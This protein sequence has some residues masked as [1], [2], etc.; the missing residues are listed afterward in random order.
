MMNG[1]K[2]NRLNILFALFFCF[3]GASLHAQKG[4]ISGTVSGESGKYLDLVN[5]VLDD[6]KTGT[7]TNS[8][9]Y[10]E[11]AVPANDSTIIYAKYVGYLVAS[12]KIF[13]KEGEH[14]TVNF[15]LKA[16]ATDIDGVTIEDREIR[17]STFSSIDPKTVLVI[18][19][20]SGDIGSLIKTLPGVSASNELSSQYSVR[21]GSYDENIIYVNGIEIFRPFLTRTG[22]QEGLSFVNSDLISSIYF[23]AGGFE[24]RYGDKMSSVLDIKYRKPTEFHVSATLSLLSSSLHI[25]DKIGKFTYLV[26]VRQKTSSY[27][28]GSLDTKGEYKPSFTD[29]QGL[30]TYSFNK[31]WELSFLGN[32]SRNIYRFVPKT[33]E[34]VFGTISEAYKVMMYM[35]GNENDKFNNGTGALS[36]KYA[37]TDNTN[38]TLTLSTYKSIESENY[39]ILSEYWLSAIDESM[40]SENYG[41]DTEVLGVGTFLSHARNR[42]E[43]SFY[44]ADLKGSTQIGDH[45]IQWG[46]QYRHEDIYDIVKQWDMTDSAGYT[47]PTSVD[48]IGVS[49]DIYDADFTLNLYENVA[50]INSLHSNRMSAFVQDAWSFEGR[51]ATYHLTYGVRATYWDVNKQFNVSP[52]ATFSI[53]PEWKHD[54]LFRFSTGYYCQ[55]PTYREMRDTDGVL[56]TDVKAQTSIHLVAGMDWNLNL[57]GRPFKFISEAYYK[58]LPHLIPYTIDNVMIQYHPEYSTQGYSTGLD[59]KLCGEFVRGV[60]SWISLS[61]MKTEERL[62]GGEYFPRPSDQLVNFS[63]FLQDYIPNNPR[64][65]M[66]LN[67]MFGTGLPV[68]PPYMELFTQKYTSRYAPYRRVDIGFSWQIVS[69]MVRSDWNF[70]NRFTDISL[71]AE[72]LNILDISNTISYTWITD[73]SGRLYGV[74]DY[75]TPLMANIKLSVKY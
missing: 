58:Y 50:A 5:I 26:G 12:V 2:R 48:S 68:I 63:I 11:I 62:K 57:W 69:D 54:M 72:I 34:T 14:N 22:Q 16:S 41:E 4:M 1:K 23:S 60:D 10:Y 64:F 51:K 52:R 49:S 7:T 38:L 13:V 47:I 9:G 24:A 59:I 32:Y 31:K 20:V 28:L 75:L 25:E 39:D 45:Y 30:L 70:L 43:S 17:N 21:G 73:V 74:P 46:A 19:S 29:V 8:S 15:I 44:T 71:T 67:L 37:P 65:K 35:E 18:P 33:R 56:H 61:L 27:L 42:Y 66:Q 36:L 6:G 40:G 53:T 55:P 3:V